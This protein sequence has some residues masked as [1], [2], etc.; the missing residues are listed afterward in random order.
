MND[1]QIGEN[2]ADE[3]RIE[4]FMQA[5]MS[6]ILSSESCSKKRQ[7]VQILGG[8]RAEWKN[9]NIKSS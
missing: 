3:G 5:I 1:K 8:Y 2:Q 9:L 4:E 7:T 6:I